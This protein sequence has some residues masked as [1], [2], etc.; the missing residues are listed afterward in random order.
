MK[1]T[2][3]TRP[4]NLKN[5]TEEEFVDLV[6]RDMN[7]FFYIF[8]GQEAFVFE[9]DYD[10]GPKNINLHIQ[11]DNQDCKLRRCLRALARSKNFEKAIGWKLEY[12]QD[13][14]TGKIRFS[15]SFNVYFEESYQKTIEENSEKKAK[16]IMDFYNTLDYKGD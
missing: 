2:F 1:Y 6:R 9:I 11:L 3:I 12:D 14:E 4:L 13:P 8:P 5:T 15:P 7:T 16:E 10:Y